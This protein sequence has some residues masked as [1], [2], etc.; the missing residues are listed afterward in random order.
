MFAK[1]RHAMNEEDLLQQ[2]QLNWMHQQNRRVLSGA[3]GCWCCMNGTKINENNSQTLIAPRQKLNTQ[4]TFGTRSIMPYC[5]T[6]LSVPV[7]MVNC[8]HFKCDANSAP[9]YRSMIM[10]LNRVCVCVCLNA[11]KGKIVCCNLYKS[12]ITNP[13]LE[14]LMEKLL[15]RVMWVVRENI[16]LNSFALSKRKMGRKATGSDFFFAITFCNDSTSCVWRGRG[17]PKSTTNALIIQH[18][19]HVVCFL[20]WI[21]LFCDDMWYRYWMSHSKWL[22]RNG[23]RN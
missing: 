12:A 23:K 7:S 2:K 5:H 8:C 4:T 1:P 20:S 19:F 13:T 21:C 14:N 6:P 22:W 11:A 3:N 16:K 17:C 9:T 18:N 15:F 10:D